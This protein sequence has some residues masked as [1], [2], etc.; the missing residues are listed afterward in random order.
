MKSPEAKSVFR[1]SLQILTAETIKIKISHNSPPD[2]QTVC[3]TVGRDKRHFG[4]LA[5]SPCLMQLLVLGNRSYFIFLSLTSRL[6]VS[7]CATQSALVCC[8]VSYKLIN[9]YE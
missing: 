6:F 1:R 8:G 5:P 4:G 2:S 3:F 7:F 9:E